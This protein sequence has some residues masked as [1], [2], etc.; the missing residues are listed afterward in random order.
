MI[1]LKLE[2]TLIACLG[3]R[4]GRCWHCQPELMKKPFPPSAPNVGQEGE[5]LETRQTTTITVDFSVCLQHL[6]R[7]PVDS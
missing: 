5:H 7:Y 6:Q 4:Q 1:N 2:V 3:E